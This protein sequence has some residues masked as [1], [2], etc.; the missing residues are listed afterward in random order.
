MT[1]DPHQ[2]VSAL[3]GVGPKLEETLQRLNIYRLIDLLLHLPYRYQDRS[4]LTPLDQ[5]TAGE[6]YFIQGRIADIR[7][8][9]GNR[10]SLKV[11]VEDDLGRVHLRFF[12]FSKYQKAALEKADYVR[13]YGDFRFFGKELSVAHP[14]YETFTGEPTAPTPGL[15]PIYPATQG[16]AQARIR[17][18]LG[19]LCELDWPQE[20][21]TPYAKLLYL[22]HPPA[23]ASQAE[24]ES[25]QAEVALDELS[26]YCLVMKGRALK[27]QRTL[28]TAL[29]RG[30]G[31]GRELLDRLGFHLTRAQARVVSEVLDDLQQTVPMLRLIQGD[32]GS[33]KT[34][35]AAF[36]AIRAAENGFQTAL[37]APTELLAEQHY[38][39][40]QAWLAPLNINVTLLTGQMTAAEQK[41]AQTAIL[42]GQA[43]VAIGTHALFQNKVSFPQL[44]LVIV[45]EQHRF[46]VH[47]RMSL[48]QKGTDSAPHQLVMT[49]TPI[50]RTLTMALYTDM[51]VSVIDELPPGRQPITTYTVEA[52]RRSEIVEQIHKSIRQ[53]QQ[54]YWV[55]TLIDDS[56]EIDATSATSHHAELKEALPQHRVGLLHGRMKSDEK[57]HTMASFKAGEIDILVATTVVEVGVDVPNATYMVIENAERLGLAQLHQLRGRVGRGTIASHCFLLFSSGLSTP[58]KTR[59]TAMRDSQDGFYLAE[60][61]L[62]LRGPGDILGTRQSGEQSFHIA[63]LA[64]HAHLIPQAMQRGTDLLERRDALDAATTLN[65]LLKTWAP[66][67]SSS[68]TV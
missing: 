54:A 50:P 67:D 43:S 33:G 14:E 8:V 27:R 24:I 15:T 42:S 38:I 65:N 63:D 36:A 25:V 18:L 55:C 35:I 57:V 20:P 10:R 11:T 26:A 41:K 46:G 58:A 68:L 6:A 59:L 66:S 62:K 19:T 22:H 16:L 17:R 56:D 30:A 4:Q 3:K 53:G 31:R 47:Q 9:F 12:Y 21:G 2:P 44:A 5:I 28:A 32:V 29:P 64:L 40:F 13:A 48:Q 49:A 7:V 52:R 23:D 61:D 1:V 45:D 39:N 60:Q 34:I 37:M 51:A